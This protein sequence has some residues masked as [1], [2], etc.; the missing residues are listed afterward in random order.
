MEITELWGKLFGC[1]KLSLPLWHNEDH[2]LKVELERIDIFRT[3]GGLGYLRDSLGPL[4]SVTMAHNSRND[5]FSITL[6]NQSTRL[7]YGNF[8]N[9]NKYFLFSINLQSLLCIYSTTARVIF[10]TL[11]FYFW[12]SDH[13]SIFR[14]CFKEMTIACISDWK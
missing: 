6:V 7:I 12:S 5:F 2:S 4:A 1:S 13:I 14:W 11:K 9:Q 3:G 8:I 10:G